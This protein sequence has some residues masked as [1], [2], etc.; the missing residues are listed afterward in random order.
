MGRGFVNDINKVGGR[1]R[2]SARGSE[3]KLTH[4][5]VAQQITAGPAGCDLASD[6]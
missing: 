2:D 1:A 3:V 5:V 4:S 6:Q